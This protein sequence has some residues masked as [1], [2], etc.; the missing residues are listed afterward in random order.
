MICCVIFLRGCSQE[1]E[2]KKEMKNME[3]ALLTATEKQET[4]T[5]I[6]LLKKGADIN[7][8]DSKGRTPLMIATYKND[9]KTAKALIEAGADVNIPDNDGVTPLE[10]ARAHNFEEI[11]KILLE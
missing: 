8:T 11:E 3:T 7:I 1:Q 5:V 2:V 4:T 10:H 6:S 9:V